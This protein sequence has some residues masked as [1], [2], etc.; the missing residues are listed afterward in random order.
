MKLKIE[1]TETGEVFNMRM[2]SR[3]VELPQDKYTGFFL[4]LSLQ[5]LF[6]AQY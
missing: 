5:C 4:T 6:D 3:F 1:S 2:E